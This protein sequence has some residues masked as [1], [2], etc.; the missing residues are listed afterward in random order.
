MIT[1]T[2]VLL[3]S[4]RQPGATVSVLHSIQVA[5]EC[6]VLAAAEAGVVQIRPLRHNETSPTQP[7]LPK[8]WWKQN[9]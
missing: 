1:A 7:L 6:H 2:Y 8:R 5:K 3:F 9:W 4:P